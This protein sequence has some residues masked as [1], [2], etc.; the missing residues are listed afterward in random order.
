L[1]GI[2]EFA[3]RF[4]SVLFSSLAAGILYV[5]S[6]KYFNKMTALIALLIYTSSNEMFFYSH[7]ARCYAILFF[8]T[9]SSSY[10][11]FSLME[12]K[13]PP[14][15]I[16]LGVINFLLIYTH[17]LTGLLLSFQA[18]LIF[19]FYNK[20]FAKQ[21]SVAFLITFSLA[22]W[23]FTQKTIFLIFNHEKSFWLPKAS[24]YDLK[25]TL[26]DF[27]NGK[28]IFF[29][30]FILILAILIVVYPT[31]PNL[32]LKQVIK[33]KPLYIFLCGVGTIFVCY[34]IGTIVPVFTKRYVVFSIPFVC[35]LIG[36]IIS[37]ISNSR[38]KYIAVGLVCLISLYSF[39]KIDFHTPKH[40]NYRDAM[41]CIKKE[42]T[43]NT[44]MLVQTKDMGALFA[45]YYDKNI[46]T[47]YKNIDADL[48]KE[49]I[50]TISG[51]E[52]LKAIDFTKYDKV[53]L[54][55]TFVQQN[56][57]NDAFLNEIATHYKNRTSVKD[58]EGI[59]IT[60]FN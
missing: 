14:S 38:L 3:I 17:Y 25:M 35:A 29:F 27:F 9:L 46:F 13:S 21:I 52:D 22:F 54:T 33:I 5:F 30:Y 48:N 37:K 51:I 28:E 10:F 12:K 44:I 41:G 49:S 15:V 60:V 57:E 47:D 18:L 39:T 53:I 23:R 26:Y 56:K 58:Y 11:Y 6:L 19:V 2:S 36:F 32:K 16:L 4:S 43:V 24:F 55:Q 20:Q 7:E 1:F 42:K 45:Y 34:G 59:A 50:Y 40:M 8:L 31:N